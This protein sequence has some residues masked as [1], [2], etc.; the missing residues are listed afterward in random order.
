MMTNQTLL[1]SLHEDIEDILRLLY[2]RVHENTLLSRN[3]AR[4]SKESL[5]LLHLKFGEI[6]FGLKDFNALLHQQV[7]LNE[8]TKEEK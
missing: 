7:N 3:N 6:Y 5:D 4:L 1:Q 2:L 8:E